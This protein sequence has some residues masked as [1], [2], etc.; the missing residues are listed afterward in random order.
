M[1]SIIKVDRI[2]DST[3]LGKVDIPVGVDTGIMNADQL[4]SDTWKNQDGTE[5]Y[6]CRAWVNFDGTTT[7]PT[8]RA[9]GNVSSVVRN[10][11][12]N[13]T[14]SFATPLED[15][16]YSVS[17]TANLEATTTAASSALAISLQT[18]SVVI[19]TGAANADTMVDRVNNFMSIFR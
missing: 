13:F 16:N 10:S 11:T 18:G 4:V 3:E 9:S 15:T 7:P 6:K 14:V 19:V 12:G 5:N 2:L 1:A 17:V 8:I